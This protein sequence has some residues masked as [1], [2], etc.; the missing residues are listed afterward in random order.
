[1]SDVNS[2]E[3]WTLKGVNLHLRTLRYEARHSL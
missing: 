3:R 2:E 1:M